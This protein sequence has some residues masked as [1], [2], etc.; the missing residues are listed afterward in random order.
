MRLK[1][2]TWNIGGGKQLREGEDPSLMVSYSIDAVQDIAR[3]L[4]R[5]SPDIITLQE[6]HGNHDGHSNQ[7]KEIAELL[8]YKYSFFHATSTSHLDP[9]KTIGNGIIS[10]HSMCNQ[11]GGVFLNP[12]LS[13]E[14]QGRFVTSHDKGYVAC[15]VDVNGREVFVATLHMLPFEPFE[16]EFGSGIGQAI[17]RSMEDA[18]LPTSP[19][20]LIQGDFNINSEQIGSIFP[21]LLTKGM[22]EVSIDR[23]TTPKGKRLDHVLCREMALVSIVV[24]PDVRTDHYPVTCSFVI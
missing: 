19:V 13:A 9:D 3:W 6:A 10:R 4:R 23:P 20:A 24:D 2:T 22:S 18:L 21:N 17:L 1:T 7:V 12:N 16:I 8:G 11:I 15:R 14:I 5:A